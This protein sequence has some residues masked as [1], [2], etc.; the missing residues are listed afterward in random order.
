ML[1]TKTLPHFFL[2]EC[3]LLDIYIQIRIWDDFPAE[4]KH[5]WLTFL[6]AIK[7]HSI[8]VLSKLYFVSGLFR[9]MLCLIKITD[10]H[11]WKGN[12]SMISWSHGVFHKRRRSWWK[13]AT[14]KT[15]PVFMRCEP[16]RVWAS[17]LDVDRE[18]KCIR[19]IIWTPEQRG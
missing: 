7:D 3:F 11:S 8:T 9:W 15:T 6:N 5:W 14:K 18:M 17:Q 13:Q 19:C 4:S 1:K 2:E 16:G 10:M 12:L